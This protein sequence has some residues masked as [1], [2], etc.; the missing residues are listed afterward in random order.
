MVAAALEMKTR[1]SVS[2]KTGHFLWSRNRF[3]RGTKRRGF[4]VGPKALRIVAEQRWRDFISSL[5][6]AA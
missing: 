3:K 4:V 1:S 6:D 5:A 2:P